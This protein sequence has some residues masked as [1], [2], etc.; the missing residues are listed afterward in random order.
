MTYMSKNIQNEFE[1][2]EHVKALHATKKK[3]E[4]EKLEIDTLCLKL[5]FRKIIPTLEFRFAGI[6]NLLFRA[7][8]I[9]GF[10]DTE[11]FHRRLQLQ[12]Q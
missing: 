2:N 12:F 3:R 8:S 7:T 1:G 5:Y 9:L 11:C 10:P 6:H 4:K